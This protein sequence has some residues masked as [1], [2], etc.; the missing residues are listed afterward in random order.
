VSRRA[1]GGELPSDQRPE[2]E[3]TERL[4]TTPPPGGRQ[5]GLG[6]QPL[7]AGLAVRAIA[8]L[9]PGYFAWVMASG[10]VSVGTDLLGYR[11][12]SEAIL[13]VTMAAFA[14]LVV[15]YA[16]RAVWLAPYVRRSLQDPSVAMAYFTFVAG[17]DVLGVRLVM[18]GQAMLSAALAGAAALAWIILNYGLPW[19]IVTRAHRPV[20]REF[21]GTLFIWVVS[22]P[23]LTA[24]TLST[25]TSW[26]EVSP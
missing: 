18:A 24:L 19:S 12:L 20:L 9:D 15:A 21:N 25:R 2:E 26:L 8:T 16:A 3:P 11:A 14:G 6:P 13:I 5:A 1:G 4:L 22:A 23:A 7:P 10:I 17:A